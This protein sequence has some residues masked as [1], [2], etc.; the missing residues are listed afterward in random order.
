MSWQTPTAAAAL[1]AWSLI[2]VP[3]PATAQLPDEPPPRPDERTFAVDVSG[4]PH[5]WHFGTGGYLGVELVDLTPELRRHFGVPEDAG[6]L[7]GSVADDSPAAATGLE[8]ADVITEI[9]GARMSDRGTVARTV[10]GL[11]AGETAEI[12]IFRDGRQLVLSAEIEERERPQLVLG[13]A[14]EAPGYAF[15]WRSAEHGNA[16]LA[17]PHPEEPSVEVP[18]VIRPERLAEIMARLDE[19]LESP[20]FQARMLEVRTNT[21]RLER[22]IRELEQRLRELS[23]EL[24]ELEQ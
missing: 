16:V 10:A 20:E 24:E 6:V 7:V 17:V 9:D 12:E 1:A 8:V 18:P 15:R 13:R 11:S 21:E 3:G 23:E 22:R 5:V 14:A 4:R 2:A 19:R